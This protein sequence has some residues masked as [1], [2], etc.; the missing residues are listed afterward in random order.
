MRKSAT[1]GREVGHPLLDKCILES[2][3]Q[4]VFQTEFS[5]EK[6]WVLAEHRIQGNAVVPGTAY[7]EM[8]RAAYEDHLKTTKIDISDVFFSAPLTVGATEQKEAYTVLERDGDHYEVRI[9]SRSIS[10]EGEL[11][12]WMEHV[13]GKIRTHTLEFRAN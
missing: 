12:K 7:L 2:T 5:V 10:Q 3:D 4:V 8:A 1:R 9:L 11:P 13:R 6:H